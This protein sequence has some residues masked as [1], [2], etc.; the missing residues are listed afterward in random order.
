[1][2]IMG[3]PPKMTCRLLNKKKRVDDVL[4]TPLVK[5]NNKKKV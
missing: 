2:Q 4:S 5:K 1:M 3:L